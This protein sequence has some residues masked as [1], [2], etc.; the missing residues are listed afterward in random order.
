MLILPHEGDSE[1]QVVRSCKP[2]L[3]ARLSA[4]RREQLRGQLGL[5]TADIFAT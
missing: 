3:Q 4:P 5:L 1:E 2:D